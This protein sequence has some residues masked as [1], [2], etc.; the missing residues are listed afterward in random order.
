MD[1]YV[2]NLRK[3]IDELPKMSREAVQAEK[4]R[5]YNEGIEKGRDLL[6]QLNGG[7][8]TQDDFEKSLNYHSRSDRQA[9][10]IKQTLEWIKSTVPTVGNLKRSDIIKMLEDLI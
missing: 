1:D 10:A 8:I 6:M 2:Y 4:D 3:E 7:K 9:E 5:I